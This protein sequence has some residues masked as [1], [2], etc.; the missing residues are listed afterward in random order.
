M[1]RPVTLFNAHLADLP[2][3]P[4]SIIRALDRIRPDR[5]LV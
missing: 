4:A 1:S 3:D 2:L 5:L